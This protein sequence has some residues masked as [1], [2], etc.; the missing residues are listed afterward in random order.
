MIQAI[1]E[2][3]QEHLS[4]IIDPSA[5]DDRLRIEGVGYGPHRVGQVFGQLVE[6]DP[7][8]LVP[9]YPLDRLDDALFAQPILQ[10]RGWG[11]IDSHGLRVDDRSAD[12]TGAVETAI[13]NFAVDDD[14]QTDAPLDVEVEEVVI[15]G[16]DSELLFRHGGRI[17]V[18]FQKNRECESFGQEPDQT[19]AGNVEMGTA[20]DFLDRVIH[21]RRG[22][23]ADSLHVPLRNPRPEIVDDRHGFFQDIGKLV[24]VGDLLPAHDVSVQVAQDP[25]D[26]GCIRQFDA[27]GVGAVPADPHQNRLLPAA[28]LALTD[29]PY[30]PKLD[31]V[32]NDRADRGAGEPRL[33]GDIGPGNDLILPDQFQ[34]RASVPLLDVLDTCNILFHVDKSGLPVLPRIICFFNERFN[35]LV[36][37]I[38]LKLI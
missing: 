36:A 11:I 14:P 3:T 17:G 21:D 16:S 18:G 12:F 28:R 9:L 23:Y 22:G 4:E 29:V 31:Q 33:L 30:V 20:S 13:V 26:M 38:F 35:S 24:L 37:F 19:L 27:D 8:L 7:D 25:A 2:I 15:R 1:L 32:G 5:Q 10:V 34:D 6:Q